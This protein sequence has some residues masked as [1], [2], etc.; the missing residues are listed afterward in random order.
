[1]RNWQLLPAGTG[2]EL[3]LIEITVINQ[4]SGSV[5]MVVDREAAE[6]RLEDGLIVRPIDRHTYPWVAR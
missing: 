6:L 1:M 4:T 5:S 3:A 2:T